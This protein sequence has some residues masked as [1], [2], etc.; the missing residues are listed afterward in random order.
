MYYLTIPAMNVVASMLPVPPPPGDFRELTIHIG[1]S[2]SDPNTRISCK[3]ENISHDSS[4]CWSN[5]R[6]R[7][8]KLPE[9]EYKLSLR[10]HTL[11]PREL[12]DIRLRVHVRSPWYASFWAYAGYLLL[13]AGLIAANVRGC[14]KKRKRKEAYLLSLERQNEQQL[15]NERLEAELEN[16]KNELMKQTSILTRKSRIMSTLLEELER[17]KSM[18]G[19]RYPLNLYTRMHSLMEKALNDQD[20]WIAF[21]TY[22]NSAHQNFIERFRRQYTDIT[23]GDLRVCCLL[24]MNLSTK[25]IASILH[26]S[27]R[28]IELRRYRLRKRIGLDS[29]TNLVDFLMNF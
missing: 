3:I 12:P 7:L 21:E 15:K 26:V 13:L 24:R 14:L 29:D 4:D 1:S 11:P 25:E 10:T 18:L 20:D 28:A 9:N 5:E 16:K 8:L 22:F 23:T 27:V 6:I 2:A 19:D 17:Q